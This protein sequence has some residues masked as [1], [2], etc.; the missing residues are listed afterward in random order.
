MI[1]IKI[2][3]SVAPSGGGG[4]S[5][6]T[7]VANYAAL[8]AAA[9]H[10]GEI[11]VCLASQGVWFINRKP[12]GFYRSD[13]AAWSFLAELPDSYFDDSILEI[14]DD[15][16]P[17]KKLKFQLSGIAPGTTRTLTA[18]DASGTI[19][20]NR[21]ALSA[22]EVAEA[23]V[24]SATTC[25]IGA[26]SSDNVRITGTTT[27]TGLGTVA[28]GTRRYV[29]FADAL[30]LT[31]DGTSLILPGGANITTAANDRMIAVS[32]GSGN[33]LVASYSKANGT[34][35]SVNQSINDFRL[36]TESGVP[37][38]TSDRTSQSTLYL[39]PYIGNK[40]A[41][42]NGSS[43]DVLSSAEVSLALSGLTS[44][45]NYDV[46]AY[47]NS[48]TL[49]LE[50]SAAWT[51]D[52]T[53]ADALARQ[54]GVLVKSGTATQ[55]YVGT[56]RT[57]GTTT[58]EDSAAARLVWNVTNQVQRR[59][60]KNSS[61]SHTYNSTTVRYW[62]ND[63]SN[64]IEV[65]CGQVT[66]AMT[67]ITAQIGGSNT[68][69]YVAADLNWVS[70]STDQSRGSFYKSF[71]SLTNDLFAGGATADS[72]PAGYHYWAIIEGSS[73]GTTTFSKFVLSGLIE[74]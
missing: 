47:N 2:P 7:E 1:S 30:T 50:L 14:S 45:K 12:A 58:T 46:F 42:Y 21:A 54:D 66:G 36:T 4:G 16:D 71:G 15:S 56:I 8:P 40:I 48:G 29:R 5:S 22:L 67:A 53:R 35:I 24:A 74:N 63:S 69:G 43:W 23:D 13:G 9:D 73:S 62:N 61:S 60:H 57:T 41:L 68:S 70:G 25:D 28:A 32:L 26:A 49:A 33:W 72:L 39:T 64:K 20:L 37:V 52:T 3:P 55:R 18:P 11:Y 17:T 38:S 51:N 31:H 27:I 19:Q 59:V 44:G 10:T 65:V 34:A 6:Y